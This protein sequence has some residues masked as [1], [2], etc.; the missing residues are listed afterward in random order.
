MS[1]E[2][3]KADAAPNRRHHPGGLRDAGIEPLYGS[4][5]RFAERI[6]K[7]LPIWKEVLRTPQR[8]ISSIYLYFSHRAAD[9]QS[10]LLAVPAMS[11]VKRRIVK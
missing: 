6:R 9:D 4:P 8:A 7:Q 3:V 2:F 5:S 10:G 11:F 1:L